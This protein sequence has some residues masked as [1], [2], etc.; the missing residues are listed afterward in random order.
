MQ[1]YGGYGYT[2]DYPVER[3]MRDSKINSI[4]EGTNGIQAMDLLFRKLGQNGGRPII[5]LG[6]DI[7]IASGGGVL[8]YSEQPV[9]VS[10]NF[11]AWLV[12]PRARR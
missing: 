1:V 11:I 6:D 2:R 5:D 4:Y 10:V 3:L 9:P 7:V 12:S 8:A